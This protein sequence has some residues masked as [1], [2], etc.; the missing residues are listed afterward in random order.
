MESIP[1][2]SLL[3]GLTQA[4]QEEAMRMARRRRVRRHGF[5]FH[6]GQEAHS[7]YA[8]LRGRVKMLQTT[9]EGQEVILHIVTPGEV[10]GAIAV[11]TETTYPASAQA[12]EESEA[13]V[14]DGGTMAWLMERYPRI[15]WNL[16]PLLLARLREAQ[17]RLR[18]LATERVERRIA[19]TLLRLA[20]Q[21]GRKVEG[22]VLLDL[23]LSRQDLAEMTGTTLYTVSR[24]L[25]RWEQEGLVEAGRER[26]LIRSPHGLVSIAEE[27]D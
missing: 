23:P 6:Q 16:L 10:F 21:V 17:D 2:F 4:E 11:L 26:V 8:L 25:S 14:W 15:A 7:L 24:V 22:G 13:L 12:L 1:T 5:F 27:L 3:Q 9:P 19:R 20:R 18:E